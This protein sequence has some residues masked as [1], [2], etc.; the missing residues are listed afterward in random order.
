MIRWQT[1]SSNLLAYVQ[2]KSSRNTKTGNEDCKQTNCRLVS[3]PT[4]LQKMTTA[5]EGC[6][7]RS[8]YKRSL[9]SMAALLHPPPVSRYSVSVGASYSQ[10]IRDEPISNFA[11]HDGVRIGRKSSEVVTAAVLQ[12]HLICSLHVEEVGVISFY[13]WLRGVSLRI[14]QRSLDG[15]YASGQSLLALL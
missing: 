4:H 9:R 12:L 3:V 2:H 5:R 15:V 7:I 11:K 8:T 1:P 6:D 14:V 13:G 10:L